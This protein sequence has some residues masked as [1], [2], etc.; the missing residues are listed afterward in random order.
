MRAFINREQGPP[1]YYISILSMKFRLSVE[2]KDSG[3]ERKSIAPSLLSDPAFSADPHTHP[4][5]V[6]GEPTWVFSP[7][8]GHPTL[9]HS[10]RG[11]TSITDFLPAPPPNTPAPP[12]PAV[13]ARS[14]P[15][16]PKEQTK[17][18]M[19]FLSRRKSSSKLPP[20]ARDKHASLPAS[21]DV[22]QR[23]DPRPV[24]G[25][26]YVSEPLATLDSRPNVRRAAT[27]GATTPRSTP[28]A[29]SVA[30]SSSRAQDLDRI[31]ELDES[32][33]LGVALHHGG[34][35]E[36]AVQA[37]RRNAENRMPLGFGSGNLNDYPRQAIHAHANV[38]SFFP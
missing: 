36:I 29:P 22:T 9:K 12:S 10:N 17:I 14:P 4:Y 25:S 32:N 5:F 18:R 11:H 1:L 15:T 20:A 30:V 33:P 7:P 21:N 3:R 27:T 35:Y 28:T 34:P 37:L 26:R 31:D 24:P 19:P 16:T 6:T 2:R 8:V 13:P 38:F 23:P